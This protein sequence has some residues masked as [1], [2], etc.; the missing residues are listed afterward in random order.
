MVPGYKVYINISYYRACV[1]VKEIE[2][3]IEKILGGENTK[4]KIRRVM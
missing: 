1:L 2:K 4:V 3:Y